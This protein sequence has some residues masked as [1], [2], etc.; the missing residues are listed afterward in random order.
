MG[1]LWRRRTACWEREQRVFERGKE[2]EE[3]PRSLCLQR[4]AHSLSSLPRAP[5][6]HT[7]VARN[8]YQ[9]PSTFT[10]GVQSLP[11]PFYQAE[12][13]RRGER[14]T[15]RDEIPKKQKQKK[16]ESIETVGTGL[17]P[18]APLPAHVGV[19]AFRTCLGEG[20]KSAGVWGGRAGGRSHAAPPVC[21]FFSALSKTARD[22]TPHAGGGVGAPARPPRPPPRAWTCKHTRLRLLSS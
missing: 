21:R 12:A 3:R 6:T 1:R 15:G 2:E 18:D 8:A 20:A 13:R 4:R 14:E 22:A 19:P 7:H 11:C 5:R 17:P 16:R 10:P 9:V